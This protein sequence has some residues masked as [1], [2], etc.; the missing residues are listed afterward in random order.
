MRSIRGFQVVI[1]RDVINLVTNPVL[2]MSNTIFP[3]VLMIVL[4]YL[5]EG[6][7][8]NEVTSYQ[9]YGLTMLIFMSLN[10]SITAANSFMENRIRRSNLRILYAP[11]SRSIVYLSKMIAT[12]IFTTACSYLLVLC[13]YL[14]F[15]LPSKG[16]TWFYFMLILTGLNL[17]AATLGVLMCCIFKSE[18]VSNQLLSIVNYSLAIVGGVFFPWDGL[19]RVAEWISMISPVKWVAEA[20]FR[21]IY[22][23]DLAFVLPTLG[24]CTVGTLLLLIGCHRL[25]N[26]EDYI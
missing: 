4:G 1:R 19:G 12:F 7:Y 26:E 8:G 3:L 10:V 6:M 5:T 9:Y 16:F 24:I 22:D 20:T 13:I 2:L 23:H 11:I 15:G 21:V 18:E 14:M 25:F 17:F